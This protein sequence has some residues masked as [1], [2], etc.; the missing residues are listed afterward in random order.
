MA[1]LGQ[2]TTWGSS[3]QH[4]ATMQCCLPRPLL[5]VGTTRP[6]TALTGP[7]EILRLRYPLKALPQSRLGKTSALCTHTCTVRS[8]LQLMLSDS[9]SHAQQAEHWKA[10]AHAVS[11]MH[12]KAEPA[13]TS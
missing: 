2:A 1:A 4:A 13:M 12:S 10:P 5:M 9:E 3:L 8:D 11:I 6:V 7:W